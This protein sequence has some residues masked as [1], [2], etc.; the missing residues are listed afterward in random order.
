MSTIAYVTKPDGK[1]KVYSGGLRVGTIDAT[2]DGEFFYQPKT[3]GKR[4]RS[5]MFASVRAVKFSLE[6]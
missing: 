1:I 4:T 6:N 2:K 5:E 3:G